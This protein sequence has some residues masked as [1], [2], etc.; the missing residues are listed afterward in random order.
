[1]NAT[2]NADNAIR[3]LQQE[4]DKPFFIC[5]GLFNPPESLTHVAGSASI[6]GA[7]TL[8]VDDPTG[9]MTAP[10]V[11]VVSYATQPDPGYPCNRHF[12]RLVEGRGKLV[13]AS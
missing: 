4:H 6:G 5:C 1:M 7:I 2:L 10:C 8:G 9:S 12:L 3:R 13:P 11:G